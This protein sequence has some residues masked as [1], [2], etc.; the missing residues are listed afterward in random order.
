MA[1]IDLCSGDVSRTRTVLDGVS[2]SVQETVIKIDGAHHPAPGLVDYGFGSCAAGNDN[3]GKPPECENL[4]R[5]TIVQQ[6]RRS[7]FHGNGMPACTPLRQTG[8]CQTDIARSADQ[9]HAI[10]EAPRACNC[11]AAGHCYTT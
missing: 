1:K 7:A 9:P 3:V 11:A 8:I 4:T 5:T 2:G 6:V 10:G